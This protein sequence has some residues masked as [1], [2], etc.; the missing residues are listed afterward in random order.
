MAEKEN[1]NLKVLIIETMQT[2]RQLLATILA[3]EYSELLFADNAD[4]GYRMALSE[5][6]DVIITDDLLPRSGGSNICERIRSNPDLCAT[7]VILT[8]AWGSSSGP[9]CRLAGERP[10]FTRSGLTIWMRKS[11]SSGFRKKMKRLSS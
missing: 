9:G 1:R 5:R 6:P 11:D 3:G 10:R 7:P 8:T 4:D 2:V